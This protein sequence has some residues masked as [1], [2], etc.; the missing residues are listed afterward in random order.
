MN[1]WGLQT[2]YDGICTV[3]VHGET[4]QKAARDQGIEPEV[5][6]D[7]MLMNLTEILNLAPRKKNG[8]F[9]MNRKLM[10]KKYVDTAYDPGYHETKLRCWCLRLVPI[11]EVTASVMLEDV[12]I[13]A[14]SLSERDLL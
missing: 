10:L 4:L 2:A 12:T 6:G 3:A 14:D 9:M 13:E 7:L 11:D 8:K 5:Q 1:V